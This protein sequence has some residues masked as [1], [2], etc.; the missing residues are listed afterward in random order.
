MLPITLS[1]IACFGWGIADFI[2]G[3]KSRT[4]PILA[5]LLISTL[6]G[7]ILLIP[8]TFG[9]GVPLPREANL[10]WAIPAGP[11]GLAAM[12]LLYKSLSVG[13]MSVLAPISAT[14]VIMPVIWG[15]VCGDA[16]S[17]L[18]LVG[19][20]MAIF[21]SL[22][23][24]MEKTPGKETKQLTRGVGLAVGSAF[25]VGLY[26]IFMDTASTHHPVW[27][28]LIMRSTTLISLIPA[29]LMTRTSI[30]MGRGSFLTILF[31][32][33]ADTLAAFSFALAASNG[34]LS[35]VAVISAMYPVITVSLSTW[36]LRERMAGIQAVG[37]FF[38]IT[39]VVLISAF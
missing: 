37:V 6:T 32:G 33:L 35:Q 36:F 27:A 9:M 5:I 12:F 2:G 30:K 21:G 24:V 28:S 29:L 10:L 38:A 18:S 11:I 39:G 14:G 17:G 31:M 34:M 19:I 22:L 23:A 16:M 26:F 7:V 3:F 20:F 13:T 1:I 15:L 4:L 25:F 8:I